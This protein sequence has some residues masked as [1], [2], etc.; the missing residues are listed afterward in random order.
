M[1]RLLLVFIFFLSCPGTAMARD[2]TREITR[3]TFD[4]Y[5][6]QNQYHVNMFVITGDG[7][8][9]TDP[10]DADAAAWLKAEI[11]KLTDQ[12]I[13]HLI[14]SHSHLDHASGGSGYGDVP[15]VIAQ[16][17]APEDIDLVEPTIRFDEELS[18]DV[19][20]KTF[21]LTYLGPGHGT[22]L[23]AIVVRPDDVGF[24]VDAVS[25]KRLFYRDFP[26]A[27]IDDWIAQ[28]RKVDSLDLDILIGGHGPVG[29][30]RDVGLGLAYLEE[31]RAEVLKGLRAGKSVDEL[32]RSV[33]ME[34]YRD[35]QS[36]GQWRALNVEGMA[37]YL[38]ESGE[39]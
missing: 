5:R 35:W 29:V 32:V 7:V 23:I 16:R 26:G 2:V 21:E 19:G 37:R 18:F 33:T 6:Y 30:K 15:N 22:D 24:V 17:N 3:V 13:T 8:V 20:D 9:V 27:S 4:V 1:Q 39:V 12:P 36:Y 34:K 25:S 14:Y 11:D 38:L 10:I 28:V 31:L